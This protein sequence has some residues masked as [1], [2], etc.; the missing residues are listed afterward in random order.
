MCVFSCGAAVSVVLDA[1]A[2]VRV[3][4]CSEDWDEN[5]LRDACWAAIGELLKNT[6][7]SD[8]PFVQAMLSYCIG[9]L[10]ESLGKPVRKPSSWVW[11]R[12]CV[13]VATVA[14]GNG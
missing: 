5:N 1:C 2:C 3:C 11:W 6:P 13:H 4:L 7:D 14:V 10:G 9:M 8:I 12:P